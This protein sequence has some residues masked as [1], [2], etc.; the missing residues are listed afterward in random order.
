MSLIRYLLSKIILLIPLILLLGFFFWIGTYLSQQFTRG[1]PQEEAGGSA[2]S[3][4]KSFFARMFSADILPDPVQVDSSK[5]FEGIEKI[6][7]AQESIITFTHFQPGELWIPKDTTWSATSSG[8]IQADTNLRNLT[9]RQGGYVYAGMSFKGDARE[10][11]FSSDGAMQLFVVNQ[12]RQIIAIGE[13]KATGVWAVPG[14]KKFN[15]V[16]RTSVN[17][18]GPCFL[19]IRSLS[20]T[21]VEVVIP[22]MCR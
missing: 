15:G 6:P 19:V 22:M 16:I 1:T 20:G 12:Q 17:Q 14:W 2:T 7:V 18:Q 4:Q 10:S 21:R 8:F 9:I 5:Q 13:A 11:M 3:T